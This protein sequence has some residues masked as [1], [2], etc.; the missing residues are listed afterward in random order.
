MTMTKAHAEPYGPKIDRL[1]AV[2]LGI[3]L[4]G[5]IVV[6]AGQLVIVTWH[7][8]RRPPRPLKL[9]YER[10]ATP[11]PSRWTPEALRPNQL[12]SRTLLGPSSAELQP[13]S[14]GGRPRGGN[15]MLASELA[16]LEPQIRIGLQANDRTRATWLDDRSP[17]A[18]AVDLT[19]LAEAAQGN[20][21]LLSYF[22]TI[23]EKIQRTA[24]MHTWFPKGEVA[25]GV[26]YIGFDLDR[27]GAIQSAAI[28]PGRSTASSTLCDI[29]LRIVKASGPFLPFPPS[30][31]GS[32]KTI[33]VPLEF[34]SGQ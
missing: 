28:V 29:A 11:R 33:V 19:N 14:E 26:V 20:P 25:G 24:N 34:I 2:A 6:L 3:S 7:G 27:T 30:L 16:N 21:V 17:L 13:S 23:R 18:A 1:F 32:S 5:H 12:E 8:S 4:A 9:V 31:Q 22:G 10:P 15:G